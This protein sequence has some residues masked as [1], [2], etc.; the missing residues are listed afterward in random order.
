MC[1]GGPKP[2][3]IV[4]RKTDSAP[5]VAVAGTRNSN[6]LLPYQRG[7]PSTVR[8]GSMVVVSVMA[9]QREETARR[10]PTIRR[11]SNC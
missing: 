7:S 4:A 6:R 8:W 9:E 11:A 10:R 3:G 2:C 1:R 5:P